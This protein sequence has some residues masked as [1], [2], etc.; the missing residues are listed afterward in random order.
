MK[1][2]QQDLIKIV[3]QA[4]TLSERL[5]DRFIP[6]KLNINN[7]Q[8]KSRLETWCQ[9]AAKGNLEKF[10][11][12]L[13][14]D[15]L[16]TN[17]IVNILGDVRLADTKQLPTWAETLWQALEID[18]DKNNL[19]VERCLDPQ[20]PIPFEE[21][22]L[23]FVQ[24]ARQK[25]I[26]QVG[27]SLHLLNEAVHISLER[28]LLKKLGILFA[29]SLHLE[30]SLFKAL[31]QSPFTLLLERLQ[32]SNSREQYQIFINNLK[33][34]NLLSFFQKYSVLARL[35]ATLTDL[36]VEEKA[37]FC[38]RLALDLPTIQQR[39]QNN[40]GQVIAIQLDLSDPHNRRRSVMIL[41]FASGLKLVY[42]PR[43]LGCEAAYFQL[44]DW[45]N[46][47]RTLLPFKL[48][49]IIDCNTHGWMEYVE[50]LP[51]QDETTAQRY[52]QRA[53]MLLCLLHVLQGVDLHHENLIAS[54]EHPVMVDLEALLHHDVREIDTNLKNHNAQSLVNQIFFNSVLRTGL[55]PNSAFEADGGK[56]QDIS[57]LGGVGQE[58]SVRT[59]KW[60]NI[61]TDNMALEYEFEKM[62][63]KANV[64]SLN[65][66]TLLPSNYADELV[67]G[68]QQ[69]YQLLIE[70]RESLLAQDSPI[71]ALAHQKVR[72][73]FRLSIVYAQLLSKA[74]QPKFLQHGIDRSIELDVL[75]RA[76]LK[77][78]KKPSIW[79]LLS[80]ELQALEQMDIPYFAANSSSDVLTVNPD[81]IIEGYLQE[82]SFDRVISR[83]QQLNDSD[84]AQQTAIIRGLL[85]SR[86]AHG[87][88]SVAPAEYPTAGLDL[89]SIP[90][91]IP[92]QFVQEAVEIAKE[93]QQR[94]IKAPD[95]SVTWIG[96]GYMPE[97]QRLQLQPLASGL[98][99]GVCGVALFLAALAK[100]TDD[101]KFRDLTL[102]ALQPLSKTL[103]QN[104]PS[105]Q[106]RITKQM[107][108]GGGIG[109]GSIV[110]A[111]VQISQFLDEPELLDIASLAASLITQE[112]IASD[113]KFDPIGGSAG[114]ILG[115]L[116]LYQATANS[117]FLEQAVSCGYHLLTNRTKSDFGFRA[118]ATLQGRL[119]T[120]L[121]HGAAGIAYALLRLYK[122]TLEPVFLEAAEEAIAYERSVFSSSVQ[123]WPQAQD[124]ASFM[125]S[126]CHGA[127]GI[128]LARLGG[129]GILDTAEIRQEIASA[130][131][132]TQQF[133]LQNLDHL[134]C[135]NFGRIEV[136][137]VA[138][139][140]LPHP[141]LEETARK[142]ATRVLARAKQV[143]NFYLFPNIAGDIYNPGFFQG[144]AGIGYQLLRLAYPSLLPT[145]MIWE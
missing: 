30:F 145:V 55:L 65:G 12:R 134:C 140:K 62:P 122:T 127:P 95:G 143:G 63:P 116:S 57:G 114:A 77:A 10:A 130:L 85:Y 126:W 76:F 106:H 3:E 4:S 96:M 26:A 6:D 138:A 40:L 7:Q 104:D 80:A 142:Q 128:G 39:F 43:G 100:I 120:G 13:A 93:L 61:N 33:A 92:T 113:Q 74:I 111:L 44:L 46:Q 89:D 87:M 79:P 75:S 50:H 60:K 70:R 108:I 78:D 2:S 102:S 59:Q 83:I 58:I 71:T 101:V 8:A 49:K 16:H 97:T 29:K 99:E 38:Q 42:K 109:L 107:G 37:E 135:G 68:F 67:S 34:D 117:T 132:T 51:C 139:S 129:L 56:A 31:K 22:Y 82:P 45:C 73:L 19:D 133:G 91:L 41:T 119:V 124:K 25:L 121:S 69:M 105:S 17:T 115:L 137:L 136:L 35:V 24:I 64:L 47:Q 32:S 23:P 20:E 18:L 144:A 88:A 72:F 98:Y 81:Q 11:K 103:Q 1:I 54:D 48:L 14:W 118:W 86:V 90:S 66:T 9:V 15:D 123:N 94:A 52:Y 131:N 110:Y 84:M 141:N 36:W 125:T 112:S 27:E 28:Q 21:V 53:G 5:S